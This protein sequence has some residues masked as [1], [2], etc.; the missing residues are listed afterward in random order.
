[1]LYNAE[2]V[3][4]GCRRLRKCLEISDLK[5]EMGKIRPD[6]DRAAGV[7]FADLDLLVR[8]WGLQK[9]QL[10][11]PTAL[12]AT[13]FPQAEHITVKGDSFFQ[14][15]NAIAGVKELGDHWFEL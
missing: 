14:V 12:A 4:L 5:G 6:L 3:A 8:A 13:H 9:D 1:M 2:R 11:T 15:G 10:G 7:V